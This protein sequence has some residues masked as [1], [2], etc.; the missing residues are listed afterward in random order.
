MIQFLHILANI[1]CCCYSYFNPSDRYIWGFP[2]GSD[3]KKICLQCRRPNYTYNLTCIFLSSNDIA[4]IFLCFFDICISSLVKCLF[5][6][7]V[8]FLIVL[9]GF[10]QLRFESFLIHSGSQ[11][12]DG[13]VLCKYFHLVF[14]FL[15]SS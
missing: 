4:H 12:F 14:S 7:F 15:S 5:V 8:H 13:Y 3:G 9:S 6:S 11:S 2:G 1:L 10:L